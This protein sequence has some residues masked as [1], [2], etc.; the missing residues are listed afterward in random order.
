MISR[1]EQFT[2]IIRVWRMLCRFVGVI[3]K[4]GVFAKPSRVFFRGIARPRQS[5][6][7]L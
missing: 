3:A 1:M 4:E 7:I 6:S 2:S 5:P